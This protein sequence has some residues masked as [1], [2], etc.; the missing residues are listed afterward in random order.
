MIK[1]TNCAHKNHKRLKIYTTC[2]LPA[3]NCDVL[4]GEKLT[5]KMSA[6]VHKIK[7]IVTANVFEHLSTKFGI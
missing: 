2:V 3:E 4:T 5:F 7:I 6:S 1:K